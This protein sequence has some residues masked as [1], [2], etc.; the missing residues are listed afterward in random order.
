MN[1]AKNEP[2]I[3]TPLV[4]L[5]R[6]RGHS[7]VLDLHTCRLFHLERDEAVV[8]EKWKNGASLET[9]SKYFPQ[10]VAE[11]EKLRSEGLFSCHQP[12]GLAF[13]IDWDGI[14]EN[15]L[16]ERGSTVLEITQRCNLRCRYCTFGGG[17]EDHRVHSSLT[18]NRDLAERSIL[19]AIKHGEWLKEISIGFY[20]GEPL[21]AFDLLKH[22]TNFAL[23]NSHDKKLRFNM[24]TN[25]TL[26]DAAKAEFLKNANFS[27]TISLDGP[28]YMHDRFR[29][30]ENGKGSYDDT[31]SGLRTLLDAYGPELQHKIGINMV[32]P[33]QAWLPYLNDLWADEPWIPRSIR[34]NAAIVDPPSGF[35]L[36]SPPSKNVVRDLK[37]E[38]FSRIKNCE[39]EITTVE[40]NTFDFSLAKIHQRCI[41]PCKRDTFFPNGCCI[42]GVRKIYVQAD[43]K[44]H[45]CERVHGTPSIGSVDAGIDLFKLKKI[46]DEYA[47]L[48]FDDCKSCP[49]IAICGLCF[50]NAY[51]NERFSIEKKRKACIS[52]RR[53][54]QELLMEYGYISQEYPYKLEEWD[55]VEIMR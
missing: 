51:E 31:I 8:F 40:K 19:S 50:K 7:F 43:G 33:T 23:L 49:I 54:R 37:V 1:K 53:F 45:I 29:V 12:L 42:P 46:I 25:G 4:H 55:K 24:T 16:H 10:E 2:C 17:F 39:P 3:Q 44:Y 5:F 22:A 28:K 18:M 13:G 21:L 6:S 20:G 15:A 38:W 32:V 9:L 11:I 48:S 34:A 27:V 14:C 30:Y 26:I 35:E 36:P 52:M 47:I 41:F